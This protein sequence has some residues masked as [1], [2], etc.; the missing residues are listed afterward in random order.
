EQ[1]ARTVDLRQA[2]PYSVP[3][4]VYA[5]TAL[6]LV[7][8]SLF[9]LRYGVSK[10]LDLKQP[11]ATMLYH[12][13]GADTPEKAARNKMPKV[14]RPDVAPD[15]DMASADQREQR[16]GDPQDGG[17][18]QAEDAPDHAPG[19]SESKNSDGSAKK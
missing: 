3:R 10:R 14:P 2:V 9:A 5:M 13:F 19:K 11:L 15:S 18:E 12:T 4:T 6:L 17:L 7:A 16:A 1:M 8:G